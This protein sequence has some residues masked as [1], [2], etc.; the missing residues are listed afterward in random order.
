MLLPSKEQPGEPEGDDDALT[1][2]QCLES[3]D[4]TLNQALEQQGLEKEWEQWKGQLGLDDP[5][6]LAMPI[7]GSLLAS[8]DCE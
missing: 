2:G 3:M 1:I 8:L 6:I 7:E 5:M 4:L